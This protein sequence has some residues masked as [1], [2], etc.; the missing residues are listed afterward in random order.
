[1]TGKKLRNSDSF[2]LRRLAEERLREN[3]ETTNP[4][5][6][7]EDSLRLLHEL[8]V[9]QVELEMQNIELRQTQIELEASRARYFDLYDLT[10]VGYCT[11]SEQGLIMQV[12]LTAATLLGAARDALVNQPIS[13]FILKD[14][15]D[16]FRR[17]HKQLFETREPQTC[18]LRMM[19]H[20]GSKFWA[21]MEATTAQDTSMNSGQADGLFISRVVLSDISKCIQAEMEMSERET[22]F[23]NIIEDTTAGYFYIDR[24][25]CFQRVNDAWLRMHGYDSPE[26][27]IGRHFS[28]TQVDSDLEAARQYVEK[29]LNGHS[30]P[31]G[32]FSR[33]CKD[34][35]VGYHT[36]S[37]HPVVQ[38]GVVVGVEGFIIDITER[39]RVDKALRE[40]ERLY[41]SLFE[42]MLNGFAYCRILFE[43]GKPR[44][45]VYL[46][47]NDAFASLTGLKDVVGR[48][49]TE[50]I[51]GIREAD[52]RLFETY[53]RVAMTGQPERFE[54]FVEALQMWFWISVYSPAHEHFVAVFD[55]I[56]ERKKAE[57]ALQKS[58]ARFRILFEKLP[59]PLCHMDK[60]GVFTFRNERFVQIFGYTADD[61]STAAEWWLRAYPDPYYRQWV[62]E[63]WDAAVRRAAV[64]GGD[65]DAIEYRVTCKNG[66][67]RVV[68]ISGITM[69]E[70]LLAMFID[71]TARKRTEEEKAGL[72]AQLHQAQKMESVGR[73]AGG[74][75]HDF[76]NMLSVIHGHAELALMKV[77]PSQPF[78]ADLKEIVKAA[79]RSADLTRQL[80]A[81]A[82]QQTVAP[83]VLDINEAMAGMLKMLQRLI[84]EDVDLN[85]QPAADLW[86]VKVDPSQIDQILANLCVNARDAISDVGKLTIETGNITVDKY[87]C[88]SHVGFVPGEYVLLAVSDD[89]SGMDKETQSH[90]FEPFF[91]TKVMGKGTGLG[92]ATVYGIVKQ[93]NGFINV[94]SEPDQG[95]TFKIYLPRYAGKAEQAWTEGAAGPALRGQEAILLVE[96]DPAILELTTQMLEMQGYTVLAASTPGEAMR[97]AREHSGETHLL[98]T[99]VVMP[100]M[101]GRDLAKNLLSLYPHL[102]RLFMS[103]YT[104]NVIAHHGVLDEGVHFI[105]KPFSMQGLAAKVREVLDSK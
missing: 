91:T 75:A 100:E 104:A 42:N 102:K 5:G 65:I 35:S 52:P 79:I 11:L 36:F 19:R 82:R 21:R 90:I 86:P 14:D 70:K 25:G 87:Y 20:D 55:V 69:E 67:E 60:D 72:E 97:L 80:L 53:T 46:A 66:E 45:F 96:D 56:T 17:C 83:Q 95:T 27:V 78:H 10:P 24:D 59:L 93:N 22:R 18:K 43:D 101:N 89:G 48:K 15:Q 61:V 77:D 68:E 64:E 76:N 34:G 30:I 38:A 7:M 94:Y 57:E 54:M 23:R 6:T 62:T 81:F 37:A 32:E 9:H 3:R 103:G 49:V 2:E 58:E 13:R 84:G 63:T 4:P 26:K 98:M 73:L 47:V 31:T 12:N 50:V 88:A 85:L 105:Q 8:Q 44:D 16:I 74:V 28:I 41:R 1:M 40:S 71:L 51:P 92:L 99:D 39:K 33:R 29:L